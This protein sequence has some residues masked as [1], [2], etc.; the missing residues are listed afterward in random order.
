MQKSDSK[1]KLSGK[2]S[3]M[4][5]KFENLQWSLLDS[6]SHSSTNINR[7]TQKG[8]GYS[9]PRDINRGAM[10]EGG[11]VITHNRVGTENS[12]TNNFD[13]QKTKIFESRSFWNRQHYCTT[14]LCENGEWGWKVAGREPNVTES[15]QRNLTVSF[16]APDYNY[17]RIPLSSLNAEADWQFRNSRDPSEWKIPPK[18]FQ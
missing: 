13:F 6:V 11:T 2:I 15:K 18:V 8:L 10:V 12:K 17:W 7:C 3:V 16:E 14:L 5:I 4:G 1:Q 9:M